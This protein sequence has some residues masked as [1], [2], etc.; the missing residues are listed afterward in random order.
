MLDHTT[1][2]YL[3]LFGITPLIFLENKHVKHP[4]VALETPTMK[5]KS[6]DWL[7]IR[8]VHVVRPISGFLQTHRYKAKIGISMYKFTTPLWLSPISWKLTLKIVGCHEI[9]MFFFVQHL[10]SPHSHSTPQKQPHEKPAPGRAVRI[11]ALPVGRPNKTPEDRLEN[12]QTG[13]GNG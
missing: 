7:R 12:G 8:G 11:A 9:H 1:S 4:F 10:L 2:I 13:R 3:D 5:L 6:G